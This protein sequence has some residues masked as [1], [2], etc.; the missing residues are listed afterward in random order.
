VAWK[1]KNYYIT[2]DQKEKKKM[3]DHKKIAAPFLCPVLSFSS[4]SSF[5]GVKKTYTTHTPAPAL[6]LPPPPPPPRSPPLRF[7]AFPI[8]SKEEVLEA[9]RKI[10]A[11]ALPNFV[12]HMRGKNPAITHTEVAQLWLRMPFERKVEYNSL[13]W[14]EDDPTLIRKS[15]YPKVL[16]RRMCSCCRDHI[17]PMC[18][19]QCSD[20]VKTHHVV[21]VFDYLA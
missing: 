20:Y 17:G 1:R 11:R 8:R 4:S 16:R 2:I 18:C 10:E 6:T 9:E 12:K 15:D 14:D 7:V 13:A 3:A 5:S 19:L 21:S